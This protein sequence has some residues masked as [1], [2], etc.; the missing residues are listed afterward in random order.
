[1]ISHL[2]ATSFGGVDWYFVAPR[3]VVAPLLA[4]LPTE[5]RCDEHFRDPAVLETPQNPYSGCA[6]QPGC[7]CVLT[8][9]LSYHGVSMARFPWPVSS[10]LKFCGPV[11]T[12]P[13]LHLGDPGRLLCAGFNK[14]QASCGDDPSVSSGCLEVISED[15][16]Q[17]LLADGKTPTLPLTATE[18]SAPAGISPYRAI[19]FLRSG[20]KP[21]GDVEAF[22]A[23]GRSKISPYVFEKN[24]PS[25]I[26]C[27]AWVSA[28]GFAENLAVLVV[29]HRGMHF[30]R[31]PVDFD[32]SPPKDLARRAV[33]ERAFRAV[34]SS[35]GSAGPPPVTLLRSRLFRW[36]ESLKRFFFNLGEAV[37]SVAI[38]I[39]A[40]G[41]ARMF[42][43]KDAAVVLAFDANPAA[44]GEEQVPQDRYHRFSAAVSDA[45]DREVVL[46][47]P[48]GGNPLCA[49]VGGEGEQGAGGGTVSVGAKGD[50]EK[51]APLEA[52]GAEKE[53][54][55]GGSNATP[56]ASGDGSSGDGSAAGGIK[57]AAAL[58][59]KERCWDKAGRKTTV[60]AVS[61]QDVLEHIPEKMKISLRVDVGGY[62]WRAL[63]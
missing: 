23:E 50:G 28:D 46:H 10:P 48:D 30:A 16:Q 22:L 17:H 39:G 54:A 8:S 21:T 18:F 55:G 36:D 45:A 34:I 5:F 25:R 14:T 31:G 57:D 11:C 56:A 2:W 41:R 37:S 7:E 62:E 53:G 63:R 12:E 42:D 51:A 38:D 26:A 15:P 9:F 49:S 24:V 29:G 13:K 3:E 32:T 6:G 58:R 43:S 27:D 19:G 35:R 40:G 44:W 52:G 20:T 61:L 4:R 1:M 33:F 60:T 47:V 59:E